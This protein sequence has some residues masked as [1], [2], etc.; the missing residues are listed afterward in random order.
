MSMSIDEVVTA[1]ELAGYIMSP[2]I[3]YK[4]RW[5]AK[6]K[7]GRLVSKTVRIPEGSKGPRQ[8]TFDPE[9]LS[10]EAA[11]QLRRAIELIVRVSVREEMSRIMRVGIE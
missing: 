4:E 5:L 9:K 6:K 1:G 11:E 3:I 10:A 2:A 8:R 7:A